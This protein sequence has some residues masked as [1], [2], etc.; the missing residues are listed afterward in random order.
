MTDKVEKENTCTCGCS[1]GQTCE[2]GPDVVG[3][4]KCVFQVS[5]MGQKKG[6]PLK[7]DGDLNDILVK[8][9]PK[10]R[11]CRKMPFISVDQ[12]IRQS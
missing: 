1:A 12:C 6:Y 5:K 10:S 4:L 3:P 9:E 8:Y 2:K 11:M 7:G